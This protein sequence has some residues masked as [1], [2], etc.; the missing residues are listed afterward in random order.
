MSIRHNYFSSDDPTHAARVLSTMLSPL[1]VQAIGGQGAI[2]LRWEGVAATG[3]FM[4]RSTTATGLVLE[5]QTTPKAWAFLIPRGGEAVIDTGEVQLR[6][7]Q[8]TVLVINGRH[9]RRIE[10]SPGRSVLFVTISPHVIE[11]RLADVFGRT[12]RLASDSRLTIGAQSPLGMALANM[13]SVIVDLLRHVPETEAHDIN[14]KRCIDAFLDILLLGLT[15]EDLS[16][17]SNAPLSHTQPAIQLAEDFMHENCRLPLDIA[18]V[19][20][21]AGV[22][23]RA[24]QYL[25]RRYR[26]MTPLEFLTDCRL[27]GLREDIIRD[28]NVKLAELA[29]RWGFTHQGHMAQRFKRKF[30]E[31]PRTLRAREKRA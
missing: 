21:H 15:E 28:P 16:R 10:L 14:L 12:L 11:K 18:Q 23:V 4:G 6:N 24:L 8:D 2:D 7:G 9:L 22:S 13:A 30:G 20:N 31:T 29:S 27:N 1:E 3:F 17:L 19:A 26:K 5:F 25:F